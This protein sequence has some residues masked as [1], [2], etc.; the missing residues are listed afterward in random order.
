MLLRRKKCQETKH[1]NHMRAR[2]P[3]NYILVL[4]CCDLPNK[5]QTSGGEIRKICRWL[6]FEEDGAGRFKLAQ[7]EISI[8]TTTDRLQKHFRG[9]KTWEMIIY[10]HSRKKIVLNLEAPGIDPGTSRMLSE[11]STIWATPPSCI[12]LTSCSLINLWYK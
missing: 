4:L 5:T 12:N 7:F 11:R 3:G 8:L 2:K 1:K 9:R 10:W 6:F